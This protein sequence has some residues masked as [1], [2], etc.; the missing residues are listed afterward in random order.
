V[1]EAVANESKLAFLHILFDGVPATG[2]IRRW[3]SQG[4]SVGGVVSQEFLFRDLKLCVG[5][6]G[7]FD[8]HVQDCLLLI[9]IERDIV[10]G[11]DRDA[12]L[13]NVGSEFVGVQSTNLARLVL[14]LL[15]VRH[16]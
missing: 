14:R 13:L 2:G 7:D 9:G 1:G 15:C 12:I 4:E 11:R 6:A 16:V 10:E 5:P 8:N 3:F